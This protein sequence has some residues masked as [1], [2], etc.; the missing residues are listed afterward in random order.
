MAENRIRHAECRDMDAITEIYRYH[1]AHGTGTFATEVPLRDDMEATWAEVRRLGLP[2]LVSETEN[3]VT[4]YAYAAPFRTRAAYRYV[5]EDSIYIHPDHM[6]QGLGSNLLTHLIQ[7][8]HMAGLYGLLAV[9]GDRANQASL[10]LHAK[11]GFMETGLLPHAGYKFDRWLD[12]VLMSKT[13][14]AYETPPQG[15]GWQ[16]CDQD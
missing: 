1:V 12:V 8:C 11:A 13:L 14:R 4:G 2:Y 5:A 9:I 3:R 10:A 16:G 15:E 6:G 7:D